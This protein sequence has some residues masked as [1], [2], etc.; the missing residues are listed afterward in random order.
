MKL[1]SPRLELICTDL[2][3]A[4]AELHEPAE[5]AR[6]LGVAPPPDWPPPLNDEHSQRFFLELLR[7]HP[8]DA[9]WTMYYFVHT[10]PGAS[11]KTAGRELVG[12]GGFKG[13][14]SQAGV[15]EIGY[16]ILP[17]FQRRGFA[18]E[19]ARG[20]V[21]AAFAW[22]QVTQV[23]ACTLPGLAPSIA[24]MQNCG[25]RFI[26]SGPEAGTVLYGVTRGE[27]LP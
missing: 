19:A 15:V 25:M 12:N 4:L 9:R 27:W 14:P 20:L 6:M 5:F 22:P 23:N 8:E 7:Q 1:T 10:T 3:L 17:S 21:A 13:P 11:D 26:G 18:T 24:V 2:A 16:S